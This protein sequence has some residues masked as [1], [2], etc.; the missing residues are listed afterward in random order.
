VWPE[1]HSK[2]TA[3][4]RCSVRDVWRNTR[5]IQLSVP[6]VEKISTVLLIKEVSTIWKRIVH[7]YHNTTGERDILSLK[8]RCDNTANGCEWVGELRSLDE[9]LASCGFTLLSCPNKCCDGDKV[10]QLLRKDVQRHIQ[11][12]CPR[13]QY[14]CPHC[15]EAGEYRE[16][17]TKHLE[18]CPMRE[19]PCPKR[20]CKRRIAQCELINH[21]KK[22]L[23]EIVPCK[24]TNI[25][26]KIE[27]LRKNMAE[28]EEDTQQHL[29]LAINRVREQESMLAHLHSREMPMKYKFTAYDHHKTTNDEIF[30]P[31]FYTSPGG[32]K[33]CISV[34]ANGH[35][36]GKG[37]HVS[38]YAYLMKG[39]N[40]DHLPWPFTGTVTVELLNQLEDK[41]HHS[42]NVTF[43]PAEASSQ[44]IVIGERSSN[45]YGIPCY[46]SHSALGYNAAKNCQYLK[47]DCL[48]FRIK[49]NARSSSK[50]WLV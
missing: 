15:Q 30:S 25:G 49:A 37:T 17:T 13:R 24:Y 5:K 31:A 12:E 18:E 48:Y 32:Y 7:N 28:H 35:K 22:C 26:C 33:M 9:H 21:K 6:S 38:I 2:S 4:E 27:A 23:F 11:K 41:N 42:Q 43:L 39:E 44:Q 10:V 29:H 1:T 45:G 20:G 47:D 16:R 36:E 34:S 19:V 46:I 40:D 3:V 50:P 8:A 14:Q